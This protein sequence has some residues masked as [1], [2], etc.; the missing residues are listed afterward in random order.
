[1][2]Q[3]TP[4]EQFDLGAIVTD[5][6]NLLR[7]KTTVIGIKM[8][9][10]VEEMEAIPKIRRPS[11]V[12]TTD[13][14]VSM[15]SR[16]GWTV[17]ITGDDLVG[18]QCR[19]VIGLAPQDEK[20][21]AGENYVGV[22]HGTAEDARK[23]QEALDVVPYGQYQAMAVSPLTSGRLNPPDICLVYATPGQMIILINGL[24][25][26]GY[27]KFEWGVVGETACADSWGR[28]LK[29]GEPSLSLPCF[30]ERRY[31][32]V[33]DEEMLMALPPAYLVKAIAGMKQLARNGL[34]YPIAPYGI[35][36][37]V[38]AGMGVSY[39]K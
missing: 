25:Y 31:G 3:Q 24:Q 7:L 33:P 38:R 32:G 8:F 17:G 36:A 9:A 12:H 37:D 6:N 26:T 2:Q 4:P 19:A 29:T 13:Q 39:K 21:L 18:A 35:Q 20:W 10:C 34:R 14:I 27:K 11:A 28:A 15:A 5:L 23:R 30:A 1:M 22:W 16:L